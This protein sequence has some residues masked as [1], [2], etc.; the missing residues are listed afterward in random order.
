[1]ANTLSRHTAEAN[2]SPYVVRVAMMEM[3]PTLVMFVFMITMVLHGCKWEQILTEKQ[4]LIKVVKM[5]LYH[6]TVQE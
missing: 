5:F 3:D 2:V 1:M 4:H 6:L